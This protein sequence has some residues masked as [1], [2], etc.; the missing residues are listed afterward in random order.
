MVSKS[1]F[2]WGLQCHKLLWIAYNQRDRIPPADAQTQ[3]VFD[4]GHEVGSLAKKLYPDHRKRAARMRSSLV[5]NG[6]DGDIGL[7]HCTYY[8]DPNQCR[9][10][11]VTQPYG[12][13]A[14]QLR[15]SL[16]L[17]KWL[18]PEVIHAPQWT[19]YYPGKAQLHVIFFPREYPAAAAA[20][21]RICS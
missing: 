1:R 10:V 20:L 3:A 14:E 16:T 2:L 11:V 15:K 9:P 8:Y 5:P 12:E 18:E 4:Q 7:D 13:F 17:G 21:R 6:E 19:F